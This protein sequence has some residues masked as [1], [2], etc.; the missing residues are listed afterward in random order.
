MEI[1]KIYQEYFATVYRYILA[2]CRD[3]IIAEEITQEAFA[4][5]VLKVGGFRGDCDI[6]VWLCQI[7]KNEYFQYL[8]KQ[9]RRGELMTNQTEDLEVCAVSEEGIPEKEVVA[10]E[11]SLRVQKLLHTLEEPYKEVFYMRTYGEMSFKDIGVIFEKTESWARVTYHRARKK[12]MEGLEN[13][14][15]L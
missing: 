7:A 10:K 5:A 9:K 4:K 15:R 8:K 12:I 14:D 1:E 6:R 11:T 3:P 13:E 2:L